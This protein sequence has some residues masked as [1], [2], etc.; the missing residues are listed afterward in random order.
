M[1]TGYHMFVEYAAGKEPARDQA[2]TNLERLCLEFIRE[3]CQGLNYSEQ[4]EKGIS[5]IPYN[6]ERDVDRL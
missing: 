1:K 5:G 6:Y 2:A 4:E 3:D